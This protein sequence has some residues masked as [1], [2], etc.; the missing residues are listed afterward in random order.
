MSN[1]PTRLASFILNNLEPILRNWEA[2]ARTIPSAAGMSRAALRDDAE[3]MLR[4]IARD[5]DTP[6]SEPAREA[7]SKGQAAPPPDG[8]DTAAEVHAAVRFA[9]GF[10]ID[11][12]VSEYRALRASVVRL[13]A[14]SQTDPQ[15]FIDLTRFNE[16]ID[17]ALTESIQEYSKKLNQSRDLFLGVL[18]HDLRTPIGSILMSA[19]YLLQTLNLTPGE[20]GKS[21]S[22]ILS[23]ATRIKTMVSDLLD[24]TLTRLGGA[25]PLAVRPMDLAKTCLEAVDEARAFHPNSTL[26]VQLTGDLHG[27][28]DHGRI[29]QVLSNLI[30]N[31]VRY[32]AADA[33][34]TVSAHGD[35]EQVVLQV[36]NA[37][38]AIPAAA[39]QRIFEPLFRERM[40]ADR[41]ERGLGLGLYIARMIAT[42]HGGSITVDST[43]EG[44]TTFAV[45]LP[46][47]P[48]GCPAAQTPSLPSN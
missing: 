26:Q 38:P 21:I 42:A 34:V 19:Q 6:Q 32:G 8:Q 3:S 20:Q 39:Q 28:W 22:R 2:F 16:A 41:P 35:S 29:A 27:T 36:H 43:D 18:G 15:D 1:S 7:K 13:W 37:G 25:L 10:D 4:T 9:E 46:R 47:Q 45:R 30:E 31:A 48:A 44:G 24:M 23:S 11:Q 40:S 33:P 5:L 12:M 14:P 17:Q